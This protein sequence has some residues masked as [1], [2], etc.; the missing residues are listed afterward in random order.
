MRNRRNFIKKFA[1]STTAL[2]LLGSVFKSSKAIN[3]IPSWYDLVDIAKWCPTVH[4]LQPQKIKVISENRAELY[5]DPKRLLPHGDPKSVFSTVAMGIFIEH[6]SIA[7]SKFDYD[8]KIEKVHN[9]IDIESKGNTLFATLA[10]VKSQ[11][12]EALDSSLIKK[13]RT[14]RTKYDEISVD[15]S[16][17]D[18]LK[19]EAELYENKFYYTKEESKIKFIKKINQEALFYDLGNDDIRNELDNLFRYSK[20][21]AEIKKDGLWSKCMGFGGGLLRS[22]FQEHE[23]WTK[24]LPK[25]VLRNTY[26]S[27]FNGTSTICWYRS[28]F[29]STEDFISDGRMFARAWLRL[30]SYN[31]Y[32]HPFGS[33]ITNPE[34]YKQINKEL[35]DKEN[36]KPIWLIF[37]VGYSKLPARSFRLETDKFFI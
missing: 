25:I 1:L 6:L 10:L 28:N 9:N 18:E 17:L 5:Y 34:A 15:D 8:V 30:T 32:M 29:K 16:V 21:N 12:E 11:K 3:S 7:A 23:R 13:R 4:N 36:N 14:S 24:G 26:L 22:V 37:R 35:N 27:S 2:S 19:S 31:L 33:L 20:E